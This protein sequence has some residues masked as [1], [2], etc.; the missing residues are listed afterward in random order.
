MQRG[1][2]HF[3]K[4]MLGRRHM[5]RQPDLPDLNPLSPLPVPPSLV[6][7]HLPGRDWWMGA[8]TRVFSVRKTWEIGIF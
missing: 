2:T 6:L 4:Q 8:E 5:E 3:Q 1:Q 7:A